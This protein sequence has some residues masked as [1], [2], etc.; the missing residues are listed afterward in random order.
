METGEGATRSGA[1]RTRTAAPKVSGAPEREAPLS[2]EQEE[3]LPSPEPP[4]AVKG[5]E[6]PQP[7]SL[8]ASPALPR[9]VPRPDIMDTW[10]ECPDLPPLD[11]AP[12]L[13]HCQA[14]LLAWSLTPLTLETQTSLCKRKISLRKRQASLAFPLLVAAFP[15]STAP[16]SLVSQTSLRR[17]TAVHLCLPVF[18]PS[19]RPALQSPWTSRLGPS[20]LDRGPS[21]DRPTLKPA[22]GR[23]RK[24]KRWNLR[25]GGLL[26]VEGDGH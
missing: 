23:G 11:L 26:R 4:A 13:Q 1:D 15:L 20:S 21:L 2:Q 14:Q 9:E 5:E 10:L 22:R 24:S 8:Q 17:S 6:V 19:H 25:V 18:A 3:P 16:F 7:P 12:R